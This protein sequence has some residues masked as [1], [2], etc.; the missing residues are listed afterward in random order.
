MIDFLAK[1]RTRRLLCQTLLDLTDRQ[2]QKTDCGQLDEVIEILQRKD[3][4]LTRLNEGQEAVKAWHAERS[5]LTADVRAECETLLAACEAD[6]KQ[7]HTATL[8][9]SELMSASRDETRQK[10]ERVTAGQATHNQ[11]Q[12]LQPG[13]SISPRLNLTH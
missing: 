4:V 12:S 2:Q 8:K 3:R 13:E 6:L 5:S 9:Q 10:L 1:F 11:Y 7:L